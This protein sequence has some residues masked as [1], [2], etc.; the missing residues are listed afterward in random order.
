MTVKIE[1]LRELDRALGELPKATGR[2]VLRRYTKAR[3]K[4]V[5][6]MAKAL[7]PV[8]EGY[9]RASITTGT[10]LNRR[11]ASQAKKEGPAFVEM[12]TGTNS[13]NGVP[14]EFGTFR[15][16]A[17][18]FIRPAW[19]AEKDGILVGIAADLGKEIDKAAARLAKKAGR[20]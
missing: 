6:D 18:P 15:T 19:D 12:H 13:R 5:E 3:L 8:D 14:R 7:V 16:R 1:G 11:Q 2:N 9:L 20:G 4:P 10:R 17:T